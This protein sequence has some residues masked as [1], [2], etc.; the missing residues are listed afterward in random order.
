M[1]GQ[2][3]K[4][5]GIVTIDQLFEHLREHRLQ[6]PAQDIAKKAGLPRS[7][8]YD[9]LGGKNVTLKTLRAIAKVCGGEVVITIK[10]GASKLNP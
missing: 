3:D 2:H 10:K 1:A 8:V 6:W 9:A 7:I 5:L 4:V